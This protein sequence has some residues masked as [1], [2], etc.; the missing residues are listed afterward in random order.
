MK[1]SIKLTTVTVLSCALCA[2]YVAPGFTQTNPYQYSNNLQKSTKP[3]YTTPQQSSYPQTSQNYS[4]GYQPYT[5]NYNANNGFPSLQGRVVT[6]P[7]NTYFKAVTTNPIS[8]EFITQGDT[9]SIFL[10]SD[11]YYN[12]NVVLPANSR[13]E[14]NAVIAVKAGRAGKNGKLK[15]HFTCATTPNGQR[16]PLSAKLATEDGTGIIAGGTTADRAMSAAKDAAVGAAGGALFGT[17]IG[18]ISGKTGR[19]AWSGTA[20]G[21]GLGLGKSVIDKGNEAAIP[22]NTPVDIILD[23]PLVVSPN[24]NN[25]Y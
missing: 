9:V 16:I 2:S 10:G 7:S 6:V 1:K 4:Q 17:V 20:V 3:V 15:I 23:Q 21:A 13:I 8:T 24:V 14:G 12:G 22:A 11:F 18:A 5:Q 19:G 25:S